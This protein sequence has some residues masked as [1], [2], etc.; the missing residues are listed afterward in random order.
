[1]KKEL[2]EPGDK[3]K[4]IISVLDTGIGIKLED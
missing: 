1:L 2:F 4:V 3:D